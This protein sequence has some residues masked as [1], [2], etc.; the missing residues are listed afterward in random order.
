VSIGLAGENKSCDMDYD[1]RYFSLI[2]APRR[3]RQEDLYE[4]KA[5]TAYMASSRPAKAT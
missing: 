1:K 2:P 4:F 5:S 3:Q